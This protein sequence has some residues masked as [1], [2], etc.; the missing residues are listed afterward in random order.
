MNKLTRLTE[1]GRL[2]GG[3]GAALLGRSDR[4]GFVRSLITTYFFTTGTADPWTAPLSVSLVSF[5]AGSVDYQPSFDDSVS[6][7]VFVFD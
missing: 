7:V 2:D 4:F 6:V 1:L 3:L 5:G